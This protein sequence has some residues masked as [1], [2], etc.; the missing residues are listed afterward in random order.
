MDPKD[1]RARY[2]FQDC[3]LFGLHLLGNNDTEPR[4]VSATTKSLAIY[5]HVSV[6][7]LPEIRK[8]I[9]K[10]GHGDI[11]GTQK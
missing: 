6:Q 1:D 11:F 7:S 9:F 10:P 2:S 8:H 3:L 4:L 5:L